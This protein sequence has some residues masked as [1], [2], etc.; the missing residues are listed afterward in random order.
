FAEFTYSYHYGDIHIPYI[1]QSEPLK[2]ETQHFLDSI[3][4]GTKPESSGL[5][6]LRVIQILEASSRSLKEN[7]AQV[8]IDGELGVIPAMA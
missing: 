6:G 8:E 7:G 5:E 2:V 4:K 1:K 3:R